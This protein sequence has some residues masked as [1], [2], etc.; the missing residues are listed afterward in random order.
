MAWWPETGPVEPKLRRKDTG[1]ETLP[2]REW[3]LEENKGKQRYAARMRDW[4]GRPYGCPCCWGWIKPSRIVRKKEIKWM[5]IMYERGWHTLGMAR[6][7]KQRHP[8]RFGNFHI[9][10]GGKVGPRWVDWEWNVEYA[11]VELDVVPSYWDEDGVMPGPCLD[12]SIVDLII[13]KKVQP[14]Y[15]PE[16]AAPSA[17]ASPLAQPV[18]VEDDLELDLDW[19]PVSLMSRGT[20]GISDEEDDEWELCSL[21][22]DI[23]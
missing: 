21:S 11:G 7:G 12:T 3:G 6:G 13:Y 14:A 20:R 10:D 8:A 9:A 22:S 5:V 4:T 18:N 1:D 17:P 23:S 16:P 15:S 2:S 19:V